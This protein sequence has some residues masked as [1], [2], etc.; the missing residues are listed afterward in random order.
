[1]LA[2]ARLAARP[3]APSL[4]RG[5]SCNALGAPRLFSSGAKV[6]DSEAQK[7][8]DLKDGQDS[9]D[10]KAAASEDLA[11]RKLK[12]RSIVEV[13]GPDAVHFLQGLVTNDLTKLQAEDEAQFAAFLSNKG[14]MLAETIVHR[15]AEDAYLLDVHE[16][17]RQRVMKLLKL[18]KLRAN[19]T[20]E[21]AAG[22]YN[23]WAV[24]GGDD[25]LS[26]GL[27]EIP[28][29]AVVKDPRDQTLGF[30]VVASAKHED[31]TRKILG[32][33]GLKEAPKHFY[34]QL[35]LLCGV[36]EG[37]EVD[38]G[39][40]LE[41]N[42]EKLNGVNFHKGC[43]TGQELVARTHFKGLVRKRVVPLT[44][45]EHTV[46]ERGLL[47]GIKIGGVPQGLELELPIDLERGNIE[48]NG[49]NRA[50]GKLVAFSPAAN[51]GL[52]LMRLEDDAETKWTQ[53]GAFSVAGQPAQVPKFPSW[54]N[55]QVN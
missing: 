45:G 13:S 14:R 20:I 41:Y 34:D 50:P 29:G 26:Q 33:L 16:S 44:V 49:S 25:K 10:V 55:K 30:R 12:D 32:K 48:D 53:D 21:D 36:P 4:I 6:D 18:F 40:P 9:K 31:A 35:R 8:K 5:A 1:M 46:Q 28:A 2:F 47:A 3:A 37:M 39:I 22:R 38:G 43:Y 23:V 15:V 11:F 27:H 24:M 51:I 19:V 7:A 54:W 17:V 52:A 42:L